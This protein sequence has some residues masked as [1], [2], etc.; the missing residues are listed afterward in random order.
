M[1]IRSLVAALPVGRR[2]SRLSLTWRRPQPLAI[3][4]SSLLGHAKDEHDRLLDTWKQV[5]A[6]A[7]GTAAIAGLFLAA[8]FAF[9][10][11][12]GLAITRE[13]T[14]LLGISLSALVGSIAFS[15]WVLLLRDASAPLSATQVASM[16]KDAL[17]MPK[18]EIAE[19]YDALLFDTLSAWEGVADSLRDQL[20]SKTRCLGWAQK[21]LLVSTFAVLVLTLR[22]LTMGRQREVEMC[23]PE[24]PERSFRLGATARSTSPLAGWAA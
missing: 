14:V 1:T 3:S 16:V 23:A 5:D 13:E 19:R 15:I 2:R 8:A 11:N 22:A 17:R 9:V 12:S 10:R 18:E 6:K 7:Q 20:D 24:L 21:A 4:T